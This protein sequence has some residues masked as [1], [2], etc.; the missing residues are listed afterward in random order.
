M[1][2]KLVQINNTS[3]YM[4]S[5]SNDTILVH[6]G[7][8]GMVMSDDLIKPKISTLK[9]HEVIVRSSRVLIN[10]DFFDAIE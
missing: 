1:I 6:S 9:V 10:S 3:R 7:E 8:I 2:G 4:L 5:N